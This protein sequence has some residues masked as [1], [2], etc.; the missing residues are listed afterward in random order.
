MKVHIKIFPIAGLC[1]QSQKMELLL[2]DGSFKE[3]LMLLQERLS[4]DKSLDNSG[5]L[6]FL[7][8]GRNLD[9]RKDTVFK[10]GDQLWLLPLISGG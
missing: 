2:A 9:T 4:L 5:K 7:H 6:M 3:V 8:N 1:N 10:D